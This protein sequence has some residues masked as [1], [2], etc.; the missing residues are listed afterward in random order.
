MGKALSIGG[1][2]FMTIGLKYQ[3]QSSLPF[4][5]NNKSSQNKHSIFYLTDVT[6][7]DGTCQFDPE[8]SGRKL[9]RLS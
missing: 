7:N 1:A 9:I 2:F 4:H 6:Q 3:P 8:A 5:K